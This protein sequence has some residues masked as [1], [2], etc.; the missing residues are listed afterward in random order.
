[1]L[2]VLLRSPFQFYI[3]LVLFG[4]GVLFALGKIKSGQGLPML[5]VLA[6]TFF[7]YVGDVFYNDYAAYFQLF[8]R[9]V[10]A[11]AW[12]QVAIFLSTF[13]FIIAVSPIQ[14]SRK[15]HLY[16]LYLNNRI[17]QP[18]YQQM[19]R[20]CFNICLA[21]WLLSVFFCLIRSPSMVLGFTMPFLGER[22]D[23]FARAQIGGGLSAIISL[24]GYLYLLAGAGF[25]LIAALSK[26]R[27]IRNLAIIFCLSV[28]SFYLLDRTRNSLVVVVV[29]AV[30]AYLF[31]RFRSSISTKLLV[32]A[33]CIAVLEI[34]FSFVMEVRSQRE[35]VSRVF[36][37]EGLSS[38]FSSQARHGGLNMFEELCWITFFMETGRLAADGGTR[39]FAEIANFI[40]R[41]LWPEKPV[42]GLDYAVLRG[43][44]MLADGSV[45]GTVSTGLVGQGTVNFGR[46]FGPMF[47]GALMAAWVLIL[48]KIDTAKTTK[49]LPLVF[50]GLVLT[51]NMGRDISLLILYPFVFGYVVFGLA[52]RSR[53]GFRTGTVVGRSG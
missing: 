20:T 15:S 29:P 13:L 8:K 43:Q 42:I 5:A 4:V 35:S 23:P 28:W 11:Q 30:M 34:W 1:M 39:Y 52:E 26:D 53:R 25:G 24:V 38:V 2:D 14:A 17:G 12:T 32:L 27:R 45:S 51:F 36:F 3:V 10:I 22:F 46:M 16:D 21:I 19:V 18:E 40:P 41:G 50:L 7:W 9:G 6:T 44:R 33:V 49:R 48:A 47:A 37:E 31:I